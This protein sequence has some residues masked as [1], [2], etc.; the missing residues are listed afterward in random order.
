M[1]SQS[2]R[3]RIDSGRTR[4]GGAEVG[5]RRQVQTWDLDDKGVPGNTYVGELVSG[6]EA[7]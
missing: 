3:Q 7:K 6:Q 4:E 1:S 2:E 5:S